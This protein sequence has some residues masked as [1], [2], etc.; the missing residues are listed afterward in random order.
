VISQRLPNVNA[1]P[2]LIEQVLLNLLKNAAEAIDMAETPQSRRVVELRVVQKSTDDQ[3]QVI[4]FQVNDG[5]PGM[6]EEHLSRL[7]EA[8]SSTKA[9]GLGIGL[10]LCRSI[11]ESH[12][13][14]IRAENIYNGS[15]V[16]GC[17]FTFT[18][19]VESSEPEGSAA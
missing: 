4:E 16:M 17:R 11:V 10:S 9:D 1:D 8:F 19:P 15:T 5:G 13:G 7:F 2:I 12:H 6:K 14:R 3:G 18:L